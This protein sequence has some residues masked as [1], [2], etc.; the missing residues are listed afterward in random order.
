MENRKGVRKPPD[1]D[2]ATE[3]ERSQNYQQ[4]GE[5]VLEDGKLQYFEADINLSQ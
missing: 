3:S 5:T 4:N 2:Y 1:I